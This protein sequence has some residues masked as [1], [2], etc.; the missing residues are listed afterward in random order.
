MELW[1]SMQTLGLPETTQSEKLEK[2]TAHQIET[3][4]YTQAPQT[5]IETKT[6][7]TE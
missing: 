7:D 4:F 3:S 6:A 5:Y 1:W 2:L